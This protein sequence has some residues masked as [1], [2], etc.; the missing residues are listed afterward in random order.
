MRDIRLFI[1]TAF[2]IIAISCSK[3]WSAP[4]SEL[5]WKKTSIP[6]YSHL[7][8]WAA[9]PDKIDEADHIPGQD[10]LSDQSQLPADVFFIHPTTH[11]D[12]GGKINWNADI[13]DSLLNHKTEASTIRFQASI[14]NASRKVYAPHYRQAHLQAYYGNDKASGE[15]ALDFAYQVV[16]AAFQYYLKNYNNNRPF[17][18]ASHS[19][20]TTHSNRLIKELIDTTVVHKT[21]VAAYLIGI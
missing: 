19:Q 15:K 10:Q 8:H 6:D 17:I 18:I 20:G 4:N 13:K 2:S 7:D 21:L 3:E 9:H 5:N 16:K 12:G 1:L 11:T 14:F